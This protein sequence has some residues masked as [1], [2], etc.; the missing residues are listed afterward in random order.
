MG[1]ARALLALSDEAEQRRI[2]RDVVARGLSVRETESLVKKIGE[3]VRPP[4]PAPSTFIRGLP[5]D[6]LRLVPGHESS[7]RQTRDARPE[8]K[9]TLALRMSSSGFMSNSRSGPEDRLFALNI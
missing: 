7:H 5:K 3:V 1:H 6:R 9:S 4:H 2:A 8:S